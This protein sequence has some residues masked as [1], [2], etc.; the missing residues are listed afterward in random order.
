MP[1]ANRTRCRLVRVEE[2][3]DDWFVKRDHVEDE[4]LSTKNIQQD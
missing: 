4:E 1:K 3:G 2:A